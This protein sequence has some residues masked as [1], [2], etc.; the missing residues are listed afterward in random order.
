MKSKFGEI[1]NIK[2]WGHA[3]FE[4]KNSSYV[5]TDPH[6]GNSIGLEKPNPKAD[7]VLVSHDHYDHNKV[8]IVEGDPVIISEVGASNVRGV[9]ILGLRTCHDK[10]NGER[11][12]DNIIFVFLVDGVKFLHLGDIGH[13]I[14][15]ETI[16]RIGE[17]DV[18]F[19]PVGGN[20]TIDADEAT[21]LVNKIQPSIVIPMHYKVT[22]L[23][24][25]IDR[26]DR[27]VEGKENVEKVGNP[28]TLPSK[29]P[30]NTE[31]KIINAPC[32]RKSVE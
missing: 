16:N 17:V 29:L 1:M 9:D 5:V 26:I 24:I 2:W 31:I 10:S 22:G 27:F 15:E 12:G 18:V 28:Y 30:E 19:I 14:S 32:M 3:C 25:P 4:I 8:S 20:F 21:E 11:R 23:S 6:D 13:M 7:V